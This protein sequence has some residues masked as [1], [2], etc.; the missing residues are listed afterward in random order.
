MGISWFE[1]QQ[2][3]E[4]NKVDK[5]RQGERERMSKRIIINSGL[6]SPYENLAFKLL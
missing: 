2:L 1:N 5:E 6:G 3:V 4:R